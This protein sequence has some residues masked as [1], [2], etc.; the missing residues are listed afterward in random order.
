MRLKKWAAQ[1]PFPGSFFVDM[2]KE[3]ENSLSSIEDNSQAEQASATEDV[4][5]PEAAEN[6]SGK[7]IFDHIYFLLLLLLLL[8]LFSGKTA[9]K[10]PPTT[11]TPLIPDGLDKES[12]LARLDDLAEEIGHVKKRLNTD[13]NYVVKNTSRML[14]QFEQK[15]LLA[16]NKVNFYTN[17]LMFTDG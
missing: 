6:Q 11:S 12:L 8:A 16:I 1:Q 15:D 10:N 3:V 7:Y 9:E 13:V 4:P 2:P 17:F 5:P 14:T